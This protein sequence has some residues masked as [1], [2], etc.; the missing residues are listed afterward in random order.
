MNADNEIGLKIIERCFMK[1]LSSLDELNIPYTY[2]TFILH[3]LSKVKNLESV[4]GVILFGSCAREEVHEQKSDVDLLVLTETDVTL[5]E[6]FYIMS[7]CTPVY[8]IGH[9]IPSDIIVNSVQHYNRFKD[10]FGMIQ[11]QA[12]REGVDISGLLR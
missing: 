11:K 2:K 10:K 1:K 6:E 4:V 9:Y 3:F 12:E 7:D 8:E 5:D